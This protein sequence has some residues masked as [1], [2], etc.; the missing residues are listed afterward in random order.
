MRIKSR[1]TYSFIEIKTDEVETTIFKDNKEDIELMIEDLTTLIE[2]L[3][4]YLNKEA[5]VSLIDND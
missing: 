1:C 2:E 4:T 3:A 5:F